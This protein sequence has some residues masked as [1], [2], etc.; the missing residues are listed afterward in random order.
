[1]SKCNS[2]GADQFKLVY[3]EDVSFETEFTLGSH[4]V[5]N[6]SNVLRRPITSTFVCSNCRS[7]VTKY[8][9]EAVKILAFKK[10]EIKLSDLNLEMQSKLKDTYPDMKPDNVITV[11]EKQQR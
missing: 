9:S 1:M 3:V 4:G 7:P 10:I 6:Y 5:P 11:L 8:E 2:C